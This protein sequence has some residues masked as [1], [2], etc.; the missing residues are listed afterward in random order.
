MPV[1]RACKEIGRATQHVGREDAELV[2]IA[3]L[4]ADPLR[5]TFSAEE[6]VPLLV[7]V[8][9]LAGLLRAHVERTLTAVDPVAHHVAFELTTADVAEARPVVFRDLIE[10]TLEAL[11]E[12]KRQVAA[13][14]VALDVLDKGGKPVHPT[15]GGEGA[16]SAVQVDVQGARLGGL[17][18]VLAA[19]QEANPSALDAVTLDAP[20]VLVKVVALADLE[21][22]KEI[23]TKGGSDLAGQL[24]GLGS[25]RK[26]PV[27]DAGQNTVELG[28][29]EIVIPG[30]K[31]RRGK[32]KS[33]DGVSALRR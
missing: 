11:E 28:L 21:R 18:G 12:I 17:L 24:E 30:A 10:T 4:D 33:A 15:A 25:G 14:N 7:N 5:V 16:G 2:A 9:L 1:R 27:R 29:A 32:S 13:R 3:Q 6:L 20:T 31:V 8:G 26:V 19:G 23:V 22:D